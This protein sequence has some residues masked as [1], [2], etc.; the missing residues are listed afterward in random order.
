MHEQHAV[1]TPAFEESLETSMSNE[2]VEK[3]SWTGTP[4]KR[5]TQ[6]PAKA[7]LMRLPQCHHSPK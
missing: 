6:M 3:V 1:V 4:K 5:R 7:R 2:T